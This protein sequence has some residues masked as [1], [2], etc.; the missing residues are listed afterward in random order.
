[1]SAL[2]R[3]VS[4][5][6]PRCLLPRDRGVA[7]WARAVGRLTAATMILLITAVAGLAVTA[8]PLA[9]REKLARAV[10]KRSAR[11]L[12]R[13]LGVRLNRSGLA[14][15]ARR[16][17][18][19]GN[20]VSW[21]D[22]I[23]VLAATDARLVAKT[24]VGQW[25]II[26]RL[27][28][29][30]GTIFIDRTNFR[31]LP[32]TV[33]EIRDALAAGAVVAVF[34]EGTTT[35]GAHPMAYRPAVFQAAIDADARVVPMTLRFRAAAGHGNPNSAFIGDETLIDSLTRVVETPEQRLDLH[36]GASLYPDTG[37][38]RKH[39]ARLAAGTTTGRHV[40]AA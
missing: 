39:L 31:T 22:I 37:A 5:C 38:S 13:A 32:G 29:L 40:L 12:L 4:D 26:G 7:G 2:F 6:G 25:P 11:A 35:C 16:A 28:R 1:M 24:E 17:L 19:V 36:V 21:L 20:H 33:A 30:G 8:T 3:P 10:L 15:P 18:L 14:V 34:P 23:A 9:V 27:A